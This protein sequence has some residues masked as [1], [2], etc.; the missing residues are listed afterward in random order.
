MDAGEIGSLE[1]I[2][3]KNVLEL[4]LLFSFQLIPLIG[5]VAVKDFRF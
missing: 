4:H 5:K 1:G 3:I 2:I